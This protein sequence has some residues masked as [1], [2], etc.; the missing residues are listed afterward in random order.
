MFSYKQKPPPAAAHAPAPSPAAARPAK[1]PPI[2]ELS[3]KL[4]MA[5]VRTAPMKAAQGGESADA[6]DVG[7]TPGAEA[8]SA[9]ENDDW[10][11]E[12]VWTEDASDSSAG[13][14]DAEA[15]GATD[16]RTALEEDA[17]AQADRV[18]GA[19][20]RPAAAQPPS[21]TAPGGAQGSAQL[22]TSSPPATAAVMGAGEAAAGQATTGNT[23]TEETAPLQAETRG[24]MESAFGESFGDVRVHTGESAAQATGAM[25]ALAYAEG[26]DITFAKGWY[27]PGTAEGNWLLAHELAHVVQHRR[28]LAGA[29]DAFRVRRVADV[30]SLAIQEHER[31]VVPGLFTNVRRRLTLRDGVVAQRL[32][33]V[34]PGTAQH[35]ALSN[36]AAR[37]ASIRRA[38]GNARFNPVRGSLPAV[39]AI[40]A[41]RQAEAADRRALPGRV[42]RTVRAESNAFVNALRDFLRG[43]ERVVQER[44]EFR[45]FDRAFGATDVQ[46][47]VAA[48]PHARFNAAEIKSLVGQET[49]D[50]TNTAVAGIRGKTRG[51]VTNRRNRGGH[52]GL[53]QHD[54]A[55]RNEAITWA[56]AQ[57]VTIPR[58]PDP[59]TI[60]TEAIKLTAAF[61]G[62]IMENLLVP[63][64]PS[65]VPAGDELKKLLFASY[66]GGFRR[67]ADAAISFQAGGSGAY[68]W[69]DIKNQPRI[70]GQMRHYVDGV[71]SRLS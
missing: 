58:T 19:G 40:N 31:T 9:E 14:G 52:V 34:T 27:A 38:V 6:E 29:V 16:T 60:P 50:M 17:D 28:G 23:A 51:I 35:T 37:W 70:T 55:A 56:A 3:F 33:L 45:R 26:A 59:R 8:A 43:R 2:N 4:A 32:G 65:P 7:E 64:L 53:G 71:V 20:H 63:A 49:G 39:S 54:A 1:A 46:T 18:A 30:Q 25:Q 69:N 66:N 13:E 61:I 12:P 67:V 5:S 10:L 15:E 47:L 57:G 36:M 42:N 48:I 21:A 62:H 68:S 22:G 11:D 41:A 24:R 44:T